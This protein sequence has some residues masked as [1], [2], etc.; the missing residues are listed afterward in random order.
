MNGNIII[1]TKSLLKK[2]NYRRVL[3]V[4]FFRLQRCTLSEFFPNEQC[5]QGHSTKQIKLLCSRPSCSKSNCVFE[6]NFNYKALNMILIYSPKLD[7]SP[8]AG[9]SH[10]FVKEMLRFFN[11]YFLTH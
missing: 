6:R 4:L 1:S 2:I 11:I 8:P 7:P 10:A 5:N 9:Q 3:G